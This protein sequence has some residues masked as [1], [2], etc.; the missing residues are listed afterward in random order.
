MTIPVAIHTMMIRSLQ[1]R[2]HE[3]VINGCS[4]IISAFSELHR[5]SLNKHIGRNM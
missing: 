4:S 5:D 3:V 2:M 1:N